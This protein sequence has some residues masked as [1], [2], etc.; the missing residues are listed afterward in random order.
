MK[1]AILIG[2]LSYNINL[3]LNTYPDENSMASIVKKTKTLGNTLNTSIIL[4][5][6]GINPYYFSTIGDDM[7]GKEIINYLHSNLINSEFINVVNNNKTNKNYIIRNLKNNSKTKIYEKDNYKYE[8][9]RQINFIPS[10]IYNESLNIKLLNDLKY[11]F[12]NTKVISYIDQL[13]EESLEILKISDYIIIPLKYAEILSNIKLQLSNKKTII[14][15]YLKTKRMFNG[16]IVIYDEQI[17]SIYENNNILN[18]VPKLGNKNLIKEN[19]FDI[20]KATFIYS[21]LED[22]D[23]DKNIKL[24]TFAKFLCD[25]NKTILDINEVVKLYE[26][27]S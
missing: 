27:N 16:I 5:K 17:G 11:K 2:N 13:N 26:E 8:L 12:V 15:I 19:S 9:S 10:I 4:A 3:F 23:L 21:I 6:Y 1:N 14:D 24:S 18:I 20:F 22:Y 7:E 25:N